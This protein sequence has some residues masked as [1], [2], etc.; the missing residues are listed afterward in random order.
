MADGL[1][2]ELLH[3]HLDRYAGLCCPV[4]D[5]FGQTYHWSILQIEYSTDLVFKSEQMLA[6][7]Y[8]QCGA[9]WL[10]FGF[11]SRLSGHMPKGWP[12][13]WSIPWDP[14]GLD[15]VSLPHP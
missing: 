8:A 14:R 12:G 7:L 4:L 9:T 2:P 6:P 13:K 11:L 15:D 3:R 1:N 10:P 5:V